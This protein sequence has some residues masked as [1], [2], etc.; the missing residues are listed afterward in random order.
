M[1]TYRIYLDNP[2]DGWENATPVG[3]GKMGAMIYGI[4]GCDRV[5]LSEE[6]IWAGSERDVTIPDFREK[7][8]TLRNFL[9]DG[10]GSEAEEWA[11]ANMKN[12]FN[13]VFSYETA[14]DLIV[15]TGD[16]DEDGEVCAYSR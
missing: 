11:I 14:G 3:C 6:R 16:T 9:I 10:K 5:Q 4:P 12:D 7:V 13:R 2:A 15:D 1:K 8:D